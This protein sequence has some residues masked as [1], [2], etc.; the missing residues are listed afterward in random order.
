MKFLVLTFILGFSA[1]VQAEIQV[2]E[3]CINHAYPCLV[4]ADANFEFK[5][6][7]LSITLT[8]KSILKITKEDKLINLELLTGRM[9]VSEKERSQE[10]FSVNSVLT[11]GPA[12]MVKREKDELDIL[13]LTKFVKTHYLI[14]AQENVPVRVRSNFLS[15]SEFVDFTRHYFTSL[16]DLKGFLAS[17]EANW[18]A[19]FQKQNESQTKALMRSVASEEKAAEERIRSEKEK[20]Q[21]LKKAK[22]ELFFR[23]FQR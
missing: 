8:P 22:E 17:V 21:A 11:D 14:S 7:H 15:K 2:P 4:R 16:K 6:D 19:E 20:A 13:S 3:D 10:T 23:T 12:F 9:S 18:S 5:Q 1:V